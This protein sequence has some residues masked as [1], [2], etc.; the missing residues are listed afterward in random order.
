MEEFGLW[1]EGGGGLWGLGG[2]GGLSAPEEVEGD[3]VLPTAW[4][5]GKEDSSAISLEGD[6]SRLDLRHTNTQNGKQS[7]AIQ[8]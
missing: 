8:M 2:L 6:E 7:M 4:P 5:L 1:G 3:P